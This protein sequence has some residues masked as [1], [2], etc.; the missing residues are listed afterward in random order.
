MFLPRARIA[1]RAYKRCVPSP[2]GESLIQLRR[3]RHVDD[4]LPTCVRGNSGPRHRAVVGVLP[5]HPRHADC[6]ARAGAGNQGRVGGA[7]ESRFPPPARTQLVPGGLQI[8]RGTLSPRRCPRSHRLLLRGRRGRLPRA[9]GERRSVRPSPFHGGRIAPRLRAGP[10]RSLDR[11]QRSGRIVLEPQFLR[12]RF[13]GWGHEDDSGVDDAIAA[14]LFQGDDRVEVHFLNRIVVRDERRQP[15]D[16]LLEGRHVAGRL[17]ADP[18]EQRVGTDRLDHPNRV[19]IRQGRQ[20]EGDVLQVFDVDP[21]EPEDEQRTVDPVAR[22]AEDDLL[23]SLHELLDEEPVEDDLPLAESPL[24][25]RGR[26]EQFLFVLESQRHRLELRLVDDLGARGFQDDGEAD[27]FRGPGDV[28]ESSDESG[29]RG[30]DPVG[31][32]HR[33]RLIVQKPRPT[34]LGR[35][36]Q[37]GRSRLLN[38]EA[39]AVLAA[40]GI[41]TAKARLV[42]RLEDLSPAAKEI[43][44]PVVLKAVGPEIVHK[45]ELQAV[46]L[47][48]RDDKELLDAASR[49][50]RRLRQQHVV[51]DGFLVQEFVEGGKEVI[52]G[53]TRDRVYGPLLLF[54]L[55]GIYVEYLKDVSFGLPPLTDRDAMRMIESIR[56]YPLLRGVRGEP[57]RDVPA[58]QEAILRLAALVSDH[59]SIQ[60]MDLNPVIALEHG[61]GYRV[62]DARIVLTPASPG[63]GA[64]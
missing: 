22:H 20:S 37:D 54:G 56:T 39:N 13:P 6:P 9:A 57:A 55:G 40:Y 53:M 1:F 2:G 47:G 28:F 21:A 8:L 63:T 5:R 26:V 7:S 19:A 60:E 3:V 62:V 23:S 64:E 35:A 15:Q 25:P 33:I 44:F 38:D 32:E 14:A 51:L 16:G 31:S 12:L 58:L 42:R 30:L 10:R 34:F 24:H 4:A 27:P 11:T 46:A 49:M 29:L 52:L 45:T 36:G 48:L 50:E 17:P 43:G 59:D 18:A 61:R 41:K